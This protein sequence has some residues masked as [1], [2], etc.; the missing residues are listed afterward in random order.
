MRPGIV[1]RRGLLDRLGAG[2]GPAVISVVAPAGYGKTTLL[3]QWARRKDPRAGWVSVDDHDNDPAVLLTYI[4]IALDRIEA[5]DPRVFRALASSGAGIEVPRRLVAAMA[6]MRDPVALVIDNLEVVANTESLDAIAALALGLPVGSQLA[7]GSR[8]GLP[9]P[10]ARLRGQ[11]EIVEISVDDL[12]MDS[13]EAGPMLLEAGV[14]LASTD[15]DELVRRTEGWPVGL[16]LAALAVNAGSS[17]TV[18]GAALTGDD[19]YIGD[20]LRSEILDRVSQAEASFLTHTSILE[21]MCGPLCDAVLGV[22]GSAALLER[23]ERRNLLVIPLDRRREWYRYHQLFRELL[24]SELR[25][26]DP[27]AV[28]EV[29][30]RAATWCEANGLPET[31]I[32][33]A[34]AAGDADTVARLLV[35]ICNPVWASGRNDTVRRWMEWFE[36]NDLI[37]RYPEIAACGALQFAVDGQPATT[38]RWADAA[39]ATSVSGALSDGSTVE[40]V[41]AYM[42]AN[43]CRKGLEAMRRDAQAAW[44]GLS[45]AS[46]FRANM[47]QVEGLSHLLEGDADRADAF[48]A[49]AVDEATRFNM[50]PF[51]ALLLVDRGSAAIERDGWAAAG[52]FADQA[53]TIMHGGQFDG[54]WTSALVYAWAARVAAVGGDAEQ[55]RLLVAR[56]ARLRPL[57][58]YALPVISARALLEMARA[59]IALTD[60]GGARAVL[61]QANDIFQQRPALGNLPQQADELRAKVETVQAE[62]LGASSL[63]T[64]ELRLLPLL[65]THLSFPQIGE[66]LHISRHT[67]KTQAVS[68]YRKL[69]VS[70]RGGAIDRMHEFGLLEHV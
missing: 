54:Y 21:R 49:R 42:R 63:T 43:L 40:G 58:T 38:E 47:I 61:R 30:L 32:D 66:R 65:P 1:P 48:F 56:A 4:A 7:I 35:E 70:S 28:P 22:T 45:P 15:L 26:S 53:M 41:V 23:L 11:G 64:A 25:R 60:P 27:Q 34:Q 37:E 46:P 36:A 52:T 9:V 3:A 31:T 55:G 62:G 57:L 18:A 51:V 20:Y 50:R 33:H 16:Y 8:D 12:A 68:I 44:R 67:V 19:R 14:E 69:G 17:S 5:I 6:R 24:M 29:H 13:H 39:E 10:A 2:V 59:Y